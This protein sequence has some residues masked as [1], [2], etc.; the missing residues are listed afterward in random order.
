MYLCISCSFGLWPGAARKE[1]FLL[2]GAIW[3]FPLSTKLE[4]AHL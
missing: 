2:E 4:R 3:A 1:I